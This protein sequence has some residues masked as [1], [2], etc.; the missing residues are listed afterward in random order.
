MSAPVSSHTGAIDLDLLMADLK[1]RVEDRRA[2]AELDPRILHMPFSVEADESGRATASV[3]LRLETAYSSKPFVGR[4]I[5]FA[6]RG[7][8]RFLY[9]F[10]NDL[11]GQLNTVLARLD[12]AQTAQERARE[13]LETR[14]GRVED[15]VSRLQRRISALEAQ[16]EPTTDRSAG[17]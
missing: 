7:A 11:V 6:K 13:A 1:R 16:A 3:R 5:T 14:T 8:I 4:P 10:L 12:E 15:D 17:A 2:A 9:H